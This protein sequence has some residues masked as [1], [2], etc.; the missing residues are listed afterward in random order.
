[1]QKINR[2]IV[3]AI[4]FSQDENILFGKKVQRNTEVY[5]D[6]WHLPGGGVEEGETKEEAM[7][8]ELQEEVGITVTKEQLQL[9]DDKGSGVAEK[10]SE[11]H[12]A[13][14]NC[15]M[16]FFI[17]QVKL[18]Q[19]AEDVVIMLSSDLGEYQWVKKEDLSLIALTPPGIE[20]FQRL[21]YL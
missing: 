20:L 11:T 14:V 12:Q 5:R 8:R 4:V 2:T 17:Y 3:S 1:M 10:Y 13:M 9:I 7:M 15:Q 21:G 16:Q 6:V 18:D 19:D